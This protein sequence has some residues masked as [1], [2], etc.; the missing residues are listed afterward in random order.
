MHDDYRGF[1]G[2]DHRDNPDFKES[3]L[4]ETDRANIETIKRLEAMD[5]E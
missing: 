1:G 2:I 4:A 3:D 5:S